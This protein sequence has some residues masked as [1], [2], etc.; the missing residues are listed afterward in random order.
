MLTAKG[1]ASIKTCAFLSKPDRREV[2]VGIDY[3][4]FTIENKWVEGYG[5]DTN[6]YFRNLPDIW[7][8][9]T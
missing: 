8:R 7:Y 5:L 4:G 3:L 2:E 1:P 9:E 6:E